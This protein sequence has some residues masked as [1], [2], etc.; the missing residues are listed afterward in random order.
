MLLNTRF[1]I[2]PVPKP[3][4]TRA[5]KWNKRP[6]VMRYR[7]FADD[8]RLCGIEIP[9][10]GSHVTFHMPMPRTWSKKKKALMDGTPHQQT[11]DWDNLAKSLC[12]AAHSN[13]SFIYDFRATKVWSYVGAIEITKTDDDCNKL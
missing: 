4:Q 13:D 11:P 12:D 6:C 1:L 3:R 7:A 10:S 2:T 8:V 9:E 5:D